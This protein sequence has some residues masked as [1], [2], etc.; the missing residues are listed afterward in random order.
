MEIELVLPIHCFL[1][2]GFSCGF[3]ISSVNTGNGRNRS[4]KDKIVIFKLE[5]CFP[6][7][8]KH[9]TDGLRNDFTLHRDMT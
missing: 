6:K 7:C 5:E 4:Q 2:P 3:S 9:T 1:L 8:R